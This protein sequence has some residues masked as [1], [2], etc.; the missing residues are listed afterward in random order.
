MTYTLSR[1]PWIGDRADSI[2][3]LKRGNTNYIKG[4]SFL[5]PQP[6]SSVREFKISDIYGYF[7]I[8]HTPLS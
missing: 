6:H 2:L 3:L 1:T 8:K 7:K 5:W 4:K